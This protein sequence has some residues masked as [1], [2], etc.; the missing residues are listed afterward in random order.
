M[1]DHLGCPKLT[2]DAA[3]DAAELDTWRAGMR[4]LAALPLVS[5]KLSGL[6][7]VRAGWM[8]RGSPAADAIGDA[9]Q[10]VFREFGAARVMAASNFPVDLH[11]G[12]APMPDL[13]AAL[14]ELVARHTDKE[15]MRA[16]FCG[17][18]ERFY[19]IKR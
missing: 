19:G 4:A 10:F 14:A 9:V 18:A 1:I 5:V 16:V 11:M 2:G 8:V 12:G 3:A 13:Y 17:N 15:Q 6:E 7:Y